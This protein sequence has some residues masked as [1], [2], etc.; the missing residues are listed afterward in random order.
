MTA[1][2]KQETPI[3][4][5]SPNSIGNNEFWFLPTKPMKVDPSPFLGELPPQ[6][7][8]AMGMNPPLGR[9]QAKPKNVRAQP[10]DSAAWP[11]GPQTLAQQRD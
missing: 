9:D 11:L 3:C 10:V 8:G 2:H 4:P 6:E 5:F 7:L 1:L